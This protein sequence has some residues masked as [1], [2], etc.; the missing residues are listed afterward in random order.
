[1]QDLAAGGIPKDLP[2]NLVTTVKTMFVESFQHIY[3]YSFVS[4]IIVFILC[5]FLKKEVL[6][7]KPK[8]DQVEAGA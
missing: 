7:S 3:M 1:M 4:M 8:E 6:S 2:T 5:W